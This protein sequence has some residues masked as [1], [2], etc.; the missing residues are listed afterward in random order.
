MKTEPSRGA[1]PASRL[2]PAPQPRAAPAAPPLTFRHLL[3]ERRAP[4]GAPERWPR[5][6]AA[7]GV[8]LSP[9]LAAGT[10]PGPD[11]PARAGPAP[12]GQPEREALGLGEHAEPALWVDPL[13]LSLCRP[14][15]CALAP[16]AAPAPPPPHGLPLEALAE[17]L[18]RR[19]AIG[20]S[21]RRGAAR[22]ELGAG[23]L[24][25][26]T[27]TVVAE[28]GEVSIELSLPPGAG[29]GDWEERLSTRLRQRG[30]A[31]REITV[32]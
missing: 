29:A 1:G 20:G 16:P 7:Q 26:A 13:Q 19:I 15:G 28:A 24:A 12:D 2:P 25:G 10:L 6:L 14:P 22:I 8:D 27:V 18:V 11:L 23:A 32:R 30:V 5:P 3:G 4:E 21:A 17:Q 31:V 9:A